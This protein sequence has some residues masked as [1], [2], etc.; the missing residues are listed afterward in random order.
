MVKENHTN[1]SAENPLALRDYVIQIQ[2]K[3]QQENVNQLSLVQDQILNFVA[4]KVQRGEHENGVID[5]SLT[6]IIRGAG[7][8]KTKKI[9]GPAYK[10]AFENIDSMMKTKFG[11]FYRDEVTGKGKW[12]T[13][14]IFDSKK[15]TV[16]LDTQDKELKLALSDRLLQMLTVGETQERFGYSINEI[17][18]LKSVM[19]RELYK[20]CLSVYPKGS[21]DISRVKLWRIQ[22][23]E[24]SDSVRIDGKT[25]QTVMK[26]FKRALEYI[27]AGGVIGLGYEIIQDEKDK[28][29][30]V[31]VRLLINWENYESPIIN[32]NG[33][34]NARDV[35][36]NPE[37]LDKTVYVASATKAIVERLNEAIDKNQINI[38]EFTFNALPHDSLS[39]K[40]IIRLNNS[41]MRE[42]NKQFDGKLDIL[43]IQEISDQLVVMVEWL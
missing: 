10:R 2:S 33:V 29:R 6:E 34:I 30:T 26:T 42:L 15:T 14:D 3:R 36:E 39:I 40:D 38:D 17:D 7:M 31:G 5:T 41:I 13:F 8:A 1:Q 24:K 43:S 28:R 22:T 27:N 37:E 23:G 32:P 16:E 20:E 21:I 11:R 35:T 9:G 25:W 4:A 18:D 19:A 12:D